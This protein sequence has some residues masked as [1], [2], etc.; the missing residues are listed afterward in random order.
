[1][2]RSEYANIAAE[3]WTSLPAQFRRPGTSGHSQNQKRGRP[4]DS[5]LEGPVYVPTIALLF[6]TDIPYGRIFSINPVRAEWSLV[7]EYG[8]EPNGMAWNPISRTIVIADFKQG[9]LSLVPKLE[10]LKRSPLAT[11]VNDSKDPMIWL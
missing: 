3:R 9:I 8:G 4:L 10:N 2:A 6:V 1:M 5:F 11:T 7:I